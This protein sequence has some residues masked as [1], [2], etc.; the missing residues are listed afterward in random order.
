MN[1]LHFQTRKPG[2]LNHLLIMPI[3]IN[4]GMP[5]GKPMVMIHSYGVMSKKGMCYLKT[6]YLQNKLNHI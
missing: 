5:G 1:Y 2:N 6:A 3:Y 4:G